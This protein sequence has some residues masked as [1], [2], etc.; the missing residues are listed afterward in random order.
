MHKRRSLFVTG[1]LLSALVLFGSTAALAQVTDAVFT[2]DGH[3]AVALDHDSIRVRWA[4]AATQ[5]NSSNI[6]S[7]EIRYQKGTMPDGAE[8]FTSIPD[9]D[10]G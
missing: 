7:F 6:E 10:E 5:P 4:I 9:I 3:E 2:S 8:S 1:I